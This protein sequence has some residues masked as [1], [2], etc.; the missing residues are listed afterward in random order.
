[1]CPAVGAVDFDGAFAAGLGEAAIDPAL[2]YAVD[3]E[4]KGLPIADVVDEDFFVAGVALDG[5]IAGRG[6]VVGVGDGG[7]LGGG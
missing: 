2:G 3:G 1:M 6:R 4:P 5:H 7:R